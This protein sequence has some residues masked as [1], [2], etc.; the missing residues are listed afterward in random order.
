M[1]GNIDPEGFTVDCEYRVFDDL[2]DFKR[3]DWRGL[4]GGD[5]FMIT[6]KYIKPRVI[7]L[8]PSIVISNLLLPVDQNTV[9]W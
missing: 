2:R 5:P 8:K 3:L 1:K 9:E 7:M 4:I 6:G